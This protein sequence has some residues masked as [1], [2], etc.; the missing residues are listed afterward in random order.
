MKL[1]LTDIAL[2]PGKQHS[3]KLDESGFGELENNVFSE[4]PIIGELSFRNVHGNIYVKGYFSTKLKTLCGRCLE[5][6]E[7]PVSADI[8][9]VLP[10]NG[11]I[12]D[13]NYLEDIDF[14]IFTD[15]ILDLTEMLR[16][17]LVL[18]IPV[19][20]FCSENCMQEKSVSEEDNNNTDNNNPFAEL[21]KDYE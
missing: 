14:P 15:N 11:K 2:N 8:E 19:Q 21:L 17:Y 7:I 20:P 6:F 9:E 1:D 16:Q 10:L 18:E 5:F 4:T 13:E 12:E 3:Y